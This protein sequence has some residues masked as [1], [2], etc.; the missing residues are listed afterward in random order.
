V[1]IVTSKRATGESPLLDVPYPGP[2]ALQNL[3]LADSV[4]AFLRHQ[5]ERVV[6]KTRLYWNII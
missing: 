6:S 2:I 5:A 3:V 1:G 4:R